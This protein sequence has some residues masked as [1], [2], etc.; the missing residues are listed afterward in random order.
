MLIVPYMNNLVEKLGIPFSKKESN[1]TIIDMLI[2]K[3][4]NIIPKGE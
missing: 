3:F 1:G 2:N 4:P